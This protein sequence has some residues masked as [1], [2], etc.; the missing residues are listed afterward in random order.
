MNAIDY[1]FPYNPDGT[2]DEC[3]I[4][5]EPHSL[6]S[7]NE[8]QYQFII[9]TYAPF[10]GTSVRVVHAATGDTLV[11]GKDYILTHRYRAASRELDKE[12]YGSVTFLNKKLTGRIN[13]SYDTL[14]G[15]YTAK[16]TPLL[17][18]LV[19]DLTLHRTATWDQLVGV[20]D[21]FP[22]LY[23]THSNSDIHDMDDVID[24]ID[25]IT[26]VL[27]GED[28]PAH[29]HD[30]PAIDGL[31][32]ALDGKI[33]NNRCVH[34]APVEP[35]LLLTGSRHFK[36]TLPTLYRET[37]T[38]IP[39]YFY[40]DDQSA[41]VSIR[42]KLEIEANV[43]DPWSYIHGFTDEIGLVTRVSGAYEGNNE[44]SVY[45]EFANPISK[46][47][48]AVVPMVVYSDIV[49]EILKGEYVWNS[50]TS[51]KGNIV[52]PK[53]YGDDERISSLEKRL[54][55]VKINTLLGENVYLII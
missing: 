36:L 1:R 14:G 26:V 12:I 39:I 4:T 43:G 35:Y 50:V 55:R 18:R 31:Q 44:A 34:F 40:N 52:V 45:V 13:V 17:H 20:P 28:K 3:K 42:G 8:D 25:R 5:D 11:S 54:H 24:A 29:H 53:S 41:L 9:P 2:L 48:M 7:I 23:H 38:T 47:T 16:D 30:I 10:F 27:T 32:D 33:D 22:S 15:D 51:L 19:Y 46:T 49:S 6:V 21:T 37:Y